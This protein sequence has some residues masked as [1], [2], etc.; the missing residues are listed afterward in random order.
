[1]FRLVLW[2]ILQVGRPHVHFGLLNP[3]VGQDEI[4]HYLLVAFAGYLLDD[5]AKNNICSQGW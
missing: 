2:D 5:A 3:G 1:M 4:P